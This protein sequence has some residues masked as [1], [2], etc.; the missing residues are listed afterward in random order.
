MRVPNRRVRTSARKSPPDG[1]SDQNSGLR[2]ARST[3]NAFPTLSRN[4]VSAVRSCRGSGAAGAS[5]PS[6]KRAANSPGSTARRRRR[7]AA[8]RGAARHRASPARAPLRGVTRCHC[9]V[10]RS[11]RSAPGSRGVAARWR[12]LRSCWRRLAVSRPGPVRPTRGPGTSPRGRHFSRRAKRHRLPRRR[13]HL[14]VEPG[15]K[16]ASK[17]LRTSK[18][19]LSLLSIL[20]FSPRPGSLGPT[21]LCYAVADAVRAVVEPGVGDVTPTS[22]LTCLRVAPAR[23]TTYQ[24]TALG[25]DG[26]WSASNW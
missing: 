22:R 18:R 4:I 16:R 26:S 15:V 24:L 13:Q 25:R 3:L 23:T 6:E 11:W 12:S 19:G 5:A 8:Q 7:T 20:I 10:N 1:T 21:Q 9:G 14:E 2:S 17:R